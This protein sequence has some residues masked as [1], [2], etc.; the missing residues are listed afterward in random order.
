MQLRQTF[1]IHLPVDLY[2]ELVKK[3]G[4]GK[5]ST[6]IRKTVEERLEHEKHC[7]GQAYKECYTN[8]PHLLKEAQL[9][10]KAQ[11]EDWLNQLSKPKKP[12][13]KNKRKYVST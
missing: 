5:I 7:L 13:I 4:K 8:N 3:V 1:S 11:I 6:Y 2:Q 10:E 12:A 9:W